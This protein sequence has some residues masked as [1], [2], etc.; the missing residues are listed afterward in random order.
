[1]EVGEW[2]VGTTLKA[3][4]NKGL[5]INVMDI[6]RIDETRQART[7]DDNVMDLER[8]DETQQAK[9]DDDNEMKLI[10]ITIWELIDDDDKQ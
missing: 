7:D 9:F 4:I 6:K 3:K 1:M 8:N 10:T 5:L 2:K